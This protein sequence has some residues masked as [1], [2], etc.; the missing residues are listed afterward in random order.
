MRLY[1]SD[2]NIEIWNIEHCDYTYLTWTLRFE[3]LWLYLSDL[4]I[5]IGHWDLSTMRT[6]FSEKWNKGNLFQYR[7]RTWILTRTLNSNDMDS[8]GLKTMYRSYPRQKLMSIM[9]TKIGITK[10]SL[11]CGEP[12]KAS[13][14]RYLQTMFHT[15]GII[16]LK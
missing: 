10:K 16:R 14:R 12:V 11:K 8:H 5:E 7:N 13:E 9:I 1:L 2:L 15:S 6:D 4:N 3:T